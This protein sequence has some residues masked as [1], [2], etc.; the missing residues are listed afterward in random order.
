MWIRNINGTDKRR[1]PYPY[2]DKTWV[3]FWEVITKN[4][5]KTGM[6]GGHVQKVKSKDRAWYIAVITP[7]QKAIIDTSYEYFGALAKI[8][9]KK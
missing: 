9:P 5:A 2:R 8:H 4:K 3:E 1:P 6:I 7:E